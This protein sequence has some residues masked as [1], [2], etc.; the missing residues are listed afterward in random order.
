MIHGNEIIDDNNGLVSREEREKGNFAIHIELAR[1]LKT[2]K[3][4]KKNL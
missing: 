1:E 3:D 4:E 2:S